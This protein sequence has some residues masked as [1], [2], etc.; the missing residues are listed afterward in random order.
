MPGASSDRSEHG[1]YSAA[2][3]HPSKRMRSDE[4]D[5]FSKSKGTLKLHSRTD[6]PKLTLDVATRIC[7]STALQLETA[8]STPSCTSAYALSSSVDHSRRSLR[9][10]SSL[11]PPAAAW[12]RH[13]LQP[14]LRFVFD[15]ATSGR[16]ASWTREWNW[17]SDAES[18][19]K[20]RQ[21]GARKGGRV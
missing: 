6:C 21:Q 5:R 12:E 16:P 18:S 14:R 13:S 19:A 8:I 4:E 20:A 2:G 7:R 15:R 17:I 3:D 10:A 1:A 9:T 11:F